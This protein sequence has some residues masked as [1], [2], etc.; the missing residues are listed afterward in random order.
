MRR[1]RRQH[2]CVG[3]RLQQQPP[4]PAWPWSGGESFADGDSDPDWVTRP[5]RVRSPSVP[6]KVGSALPEAAWLR[7][8]GLHGPT[9]WPVLCKARHTARAVR[10]SCS[11]TCTLKILTQ[12]V[13]LRLSQTLSLTLT[14]SL[15]ALSLFLWWRKPEQLT[16]PSPSSLN[17]AAAPWPSPQDLPRPNITTAPPHRTASGTK[18]R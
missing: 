5:F 10:C 1:D 11:F 6:P 15:S 3:A 9:A 8:G 17:A 4:W 12:N 2:S 14:L 16:A 7:Q 13:T 18:V